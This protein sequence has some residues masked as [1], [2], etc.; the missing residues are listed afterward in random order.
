MSTKELIQSYYNSLSDKNGT[1][2][3]LYSEEAVFSDSSKVL[4][5]KGK[6]AVIES[7]TPFLTGVASVKVK[8]L[9]IENGDACA[10][11]EY[12]YMNAKGERMNQ[13]VAEIWE[14]R[15]AKL[16]RLTIYFDLT[17]YRSFMRG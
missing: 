1:W 14:T 13:D 6:A 15:D 7:F 3:D 5:A 9:I 8:Q 4:N 10:V 17:A 12:E 16:S 2:K 11:V